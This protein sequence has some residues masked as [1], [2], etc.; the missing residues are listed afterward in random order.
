MELERNHV[1]LDCKTKEI[2]ITNSL[3]QKVSQDRL[4]RVYIKVGDGSVKSIS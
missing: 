1:K 4:G 3:I 2:F